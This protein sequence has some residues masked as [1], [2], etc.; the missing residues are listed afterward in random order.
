VAA[1]CC[2]R[3]D[4]DPVEGVVGHVRQVDPEVHP[5]PPP[6]RLGPAGT[7]GLASRLACRSGR[8]ACARRSPI[9]VL[10]RSL[11]TDPASDHSHSPRHGPMSSLPSYQSGLWAE[12]C[13]QV[14]PR[15]LG[16][17]KRQKISYPARERLLH[18]RG[19]AP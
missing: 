2:S 11:G 15:R 3:G 18:P 14:A 1:C 4:C 10:G 17:R 12:A 16:S 19:L 8:W 13:S 5:Y 7:P 9:G 6:L